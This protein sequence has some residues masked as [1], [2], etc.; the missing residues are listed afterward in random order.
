[1]CTS[2]EVRR[3]LEVDC[4]RQHQHAETFPGH[5]QTLAEARRWTPQMCSAVLR[6]FRKTV[7]RKEP[8]RIVTLRTALSRRIRSLAGSLELL[9]TW[10]WISTCHVP[11]QQPPAGVIVLTQ[12]G[13]LDS[14]MTFLFPKGYSV[15]PTAEL[16]LSI[17][18]LHVNTG[19]SSPEDMARHLRLAGASETAIATAKSL[20]CARCEEN[21]V[22]KPARPSHL[23]VEDLQ[24][25]E[26]VQGDPFEIHDTH[27]RPFWFAF[28]ID[29]ATGHGVAS[30]MDSHTSEG[31]WNAYSRGW[32][33]W[34]GPRDR[35]RCDN[36]R[37]LI[38]RT[39]AWRFAHSGTLLD[40]SAPLAPYQKANVE[41]KIRHVKECARKSIIHVQAFG[42]DEMRLIGRETSSSVNRY[43]DDSGVSSATLLFGQRLK[44]Y[45]E[46]YENGQLVGYHPNI[47]LKGGPLERRMKIREV[48]MQMVARAQSRELIKRAVTARSRPLQHV[49]AGQ[50]V[51]FYRP[52]QGRG[53]QGRP[54]PSSRSSNSLRQNGRELV[55]P[56]RRKAFP[57]ASGVL[58]RSHERR[59]PDGRPQRA[60]RDRSRPGRCRRSGL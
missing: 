36:E 30:L 34:A 31:Y 29:V 25:N 26:T 3:E 47:D 37:G 43:P 50:R 38:S 40:P 58:P 5:S 22:P 16:K 8:S 42:A 12:S 24:F 33:E 18:K 7:Q 9:E 53:G 56:L 19:H 41:K 59:A 48:T 44:L 23:P 52:P 27:G 1:M 46:F 39:N 2:P 32:L 17:K 21:R 11:C 51:F 60:S 57:G 20:R 54:R 35:M 28:H 4:D 45:G 55:G 15:N 14:G 10:N 13:T 6:G 49:E